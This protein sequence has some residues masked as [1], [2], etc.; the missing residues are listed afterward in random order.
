[1]DISTKKIQARL[2]RRAILEDIKR[3]ETTQEIVPSEWNTPCAGCNHDLHPPDSCTADDGRCECLTPDFFKGTLKVPRE[4]KDAPEFNTHPYL[5]LAA[6]LYG[7]FLHRAQSVLDNG[8]ARDDLTQLVMTL[9]D[10][11]TQW[12]KIWDVV[13]HKI[14]NDLEVRGY[15]DR[16][17]QSAEREYE[18]NRSKIA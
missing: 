12:S 6:A 9:R 15:G 14:G 5:P 10:L 7:G 4:A 1:M 13:H 8:P 18:Y 17:L 16:T 2:E 11:E 3:G